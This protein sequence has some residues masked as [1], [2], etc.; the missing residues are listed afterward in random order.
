MRMELRV[1]KLKEEAKIPF[2]AHDND[3]GMDLYACEDVTIQKGSKALVGTGIALEIPDNYVGLVWDKSG[4]ATTHGLKTLGGVVD[5]GY[6]GEVMVGLVNLGNEDYKI[7]K[8]HK[9]AQMLI[10][11]VK[12]PEIVEV[13]ELSDS[14]RGERGFGSTGK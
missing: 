8:G 14:T 4:L 6:R 12:H 2:Y 7:S 11:K 13:E 5:A 1:K 3:A 10:Q 9:I